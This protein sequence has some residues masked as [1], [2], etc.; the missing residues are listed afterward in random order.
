[1]FKNAEIEFSKQ[2]NHLY[3]EYELLFI[4]WF[5]YML[6]H[7]LLVYMNSLQ[8]LSGQKKTLNFTGVCGFN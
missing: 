8:N 5:F 3:E 4:E 1:M 2:G 7:L 6:H